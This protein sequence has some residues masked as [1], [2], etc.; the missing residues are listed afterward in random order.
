MHT[1]E[2]VLLM[3]PQTFVITQCLFLLSECSNAMPGLVLMLPPYRL[4]LMTIQS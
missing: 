3:S 4:D 2:F 1:T